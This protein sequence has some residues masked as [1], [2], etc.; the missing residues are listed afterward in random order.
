[1]DSLSSIFAAIQEKCAKSDNPDFSSSVSIIK[2]ALLLKNNMPRTGAMAKLYL[3]NPDEHIVHAWNIADDP[4]ISK[5]A[6]LIH[7]HVGYDKCIFVPKLFPPITKDLIQSEYESKTINKIDS[8]CFISLETPVLESSRPELIKE[9]VNKTKDKIQ[10][11]ILASEPLAIENNA[12]EKIGGFFHKA[13]NFVSNAEARG[14]AAKIDPRAIVIHIHGGGFT[15]GSSAS[16]RSY[17]I[18]FTNRSNFVHFSID[19]SLAPE[20][21]YPQALDDVWQ[22]YLWIINYADLILGIMI[23]N[24]SL[25]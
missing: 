12:A 6:G 23:E 9:L 8:K 13:L 7:P 14:M 11:R 16:H 25:F 21:K 1:M 5:I 20:H 24:Y 17:L 10:I 22:A 4:F 19:Y 15:A 18:P 2:E 3:S